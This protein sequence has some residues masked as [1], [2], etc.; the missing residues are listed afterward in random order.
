MPGQ[1]LRK[2]PERWRSEDWKKEWGESI[3]DV[4]KRNVEALLDVLDKYE[5]HNIVVG[6]HGTAL[7]TILDFLSPQYG[8][9]DFLRMMD[10]MPN[11]VEV[12]FDGKKVIAINELGHLE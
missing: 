5:G 4:K 2:N 3:A 11:I 10:W 9:D 8:Y 1:G 6:T 12:V 7:S